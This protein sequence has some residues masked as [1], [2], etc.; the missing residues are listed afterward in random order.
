MI[1]YLLETD[2]IIEKNKPAL[3]EP[4]HDRAGPLSCWLEYN[5]RPA[6]IT[7]VEVLIGS[8]ALS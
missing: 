8:W 3:L 5:F 7:C 2:S 1:V 4:A 6:L